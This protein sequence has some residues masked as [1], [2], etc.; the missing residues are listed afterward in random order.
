[1]VK[2]FECFLV[3]FSLDFNIVNFEHSQWT[4]HLK[5]THKRRPGRDMNVRSCR[6]TTGFSPKWINDHLENKKVQIV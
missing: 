2:E 4:Q 5:Q 3:S 1:M 6:V